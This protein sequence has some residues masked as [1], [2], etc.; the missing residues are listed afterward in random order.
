MEAFPSLRIAIDCGKAGGTLPCVFNA[1]NEEAV[2]AF[3]DNKIKYLDIPYITE[4]VASLHKN[5]A[6]PC[7][8][9]IERADAEARAA[10]QSIIANL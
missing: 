6:A 5:I 3:L 8:E 4:K 10:A 1:A 2:Y 9:D 7:I